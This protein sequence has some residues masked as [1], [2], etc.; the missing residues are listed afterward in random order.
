MEKIEVLDFL[1]KEL[2][3]RKR[4]VRVILPNDY[5]QNIHIQYPVIYMHDGQNL[6]DPS[7]VSGYSWDVAKSITKL[8]NQ[9]I[10][11]GAIIVGIDSDDTYRIPEYTN[12]ISK[13][14]EKGIK[15]LTKSNLFLPEAH[16]YGKF[17]VE[18]LKPYIDSNYRTLT[19]RLNTAIAGS[20]CGGNVSL[21]LGTVYNEIFGIVGAFS[22][23]YWIVKEDLF[24]RV[25][26]KNYLENTKIYHDMG[27][28]ESG[29]LSL[30]T[31]VKDAKRFNQILESKITDSKNRLFIFDKKATHTELFW[32]DR[33]PTFVSWAFGN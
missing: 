25:K 32:Q 8:V 11:L 26:N 6:V 29:V 13:K 28:K 2:G 10:I 27:G 12:A 19:D 7:G 4:K 23:A 14:A 3:N 5:Y 22:P 9:K 21:Y 33:F 30:F 17:I 20:S 31:C 15:K 16:L 18:V 1:I 24:D